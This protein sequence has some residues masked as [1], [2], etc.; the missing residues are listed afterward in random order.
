MDWRTFF[1]LMP[2]NLCRYMPKDVY[3]QKG[4]WEGEIYRN[5]KSMA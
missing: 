3:A 1:Y 2:R 4:P 5:I